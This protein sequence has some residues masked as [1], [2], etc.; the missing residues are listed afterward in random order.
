MEEWDGEYW[1]KT[2]REMCRGETIEDI[3]ITK[4]IVENVNIAKGM[5]E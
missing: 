3:S 2:I 1:A 5:I 4:N